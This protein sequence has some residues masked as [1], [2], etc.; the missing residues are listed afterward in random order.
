MLKLGSNPTTA[1]F[2]SFTFDLTTGAYSAAS[3]SGA[4]TNYSASSTYAGNGWWRCSI[5]MKPNTSDAA[6][7]GQIF[8]ASTF[9]VNPTYG[10]TLNNGVYIWGTQLEET[11]YLGTYALTGATA[12][13]LANTAISIRYESNVIST[14][15]N[16]LTLNTMSHRIT[17]N[18]SNVPYIVY[19]TYDN[20]AFSIIRT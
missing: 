16:T 7:T 4:A 6:F 20:V 19:P 5:T 12:N 11:P 17:S 3:V 1:S 9:S 13:V 2:V 10:G 14:S 15:G 18:T 8:L